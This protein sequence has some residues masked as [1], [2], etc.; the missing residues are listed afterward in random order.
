MIIK[1]KIKDIL[2]SN[3]TGRE[4]IFR[5]KKLT[6]NIPV[7]DMEF[8]QLINIE[9]VSSCNLACV[10]CPPHMKE[11]KNEVRKFGIMSMELFGK[12]MNEID[13]YGERRIALHKDGEPLLHPKIIKI[14]ERVKR[15]RNHVVYLTTNAHRLS[16]EVSMSIFEN[17]I[18]V[19][20]FSIGAATQEFY[21]KVRGKHFDKVIKNILSFLDLRAKSDWK[22]RVIVQIINLPQFREMENELK[23]FRKFWS[24]Y[25]VEIQEW[26]NLTWGVF[27]YKESGLKRYPCY[28]LWESTVVNSDGVVSACCMD[29]RQQLQTGNANEQNLKDIW[30]GEALRKIRKMHIEGREDELPICPTCNYWA[31]QSRL[32]EYP[33]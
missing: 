24:R 26:E 20:N 17:R 19:I 13:A 8:P 1:Q 29:W 11:F 33:L 14:L 9:T 2:S 10:H 7:P 30:K 27:D 5:Y 15:N 12:L 31:W 32:E 21:T 16:D 4:L 22:P 18:D 6:G 23:S 25:D 3:N 28:S